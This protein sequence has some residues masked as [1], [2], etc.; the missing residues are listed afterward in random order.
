MGLRGLH[1]EYKCL[2]LSVDKWAEVEFKNEVTGEIDV[3][4]VY[5]GVQLMEEKEDDKYLG[6][7]ISKD[8][9]NIKN[10]KARIGKGTGIVNK[11]LT[12]LDGIHFGKHYWSVVSCS[13]LKHGTM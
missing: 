4:D 6:D 7:V 2:D 12:M 10:I 8:G 5:D 3:K 13:I 1:E 11:I 9:K